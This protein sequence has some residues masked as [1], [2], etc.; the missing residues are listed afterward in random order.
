MLENL[1]VGFL[2]ANY[3]PTVKNLVDLNAYK[4]CRKRCW[5]PKMDI[6]CMPTVKKLVSLGAYRGCIKRYL[7]PKMSVF[8]YGERD[9]TYV[10]DLVKTVLCLSFACKYLE[11]ASFE[12]KTLLF[13]S[14]KEGVAPIVKRAARKCGASY[15]TSRWRSGTLTNWEVCHSRIAYFNALSLLKKTGKMRVFYTKKEVSRLNRVLGKLKRAFGGLRNMVRIPDCVIVVDPRCDRRA[16]SE[17]V[18]LGIPVISILDASANPDLIDMPIP[19]AIN[20][21]PALRYVL[22]ELCRAIVSF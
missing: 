7:N 16:V 11:R 1:G 18:K 20:S 6:D 3:V 15:L 8:L 17:C 2:P 12:K 9:G 4:G 19:L 22:S 13:V 5:N 21:I 14:T 10:L